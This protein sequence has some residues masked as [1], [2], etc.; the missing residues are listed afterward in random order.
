LRQVN[1]TVNPNSKAL[2]ENGA[3]S[4]GF[5]RQGDPEEAERKTSDS[6]NPQPERKV[7]QQVISTLACMHAAGT[8]HCGI[9]PENLN[10]EPTWPL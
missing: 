3:V 4:R 1:G 6:P 7:I 9:K 5:S 8:I 10:A 2:D